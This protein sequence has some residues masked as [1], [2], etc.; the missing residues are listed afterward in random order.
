[1]RSLV[2]ALLVLACLVPT[3][4]SAADSD[5]ESRF[6]RIQRNEKQEPV[7]LQ[8][9]TVKYVPA[10]GDKGVEIDLVAVVHVGEKSYYQAFNDQFAKYDSVLYELVAP[11]GTKPSKDR[12]RRC[13]SVALATWAMSAK[14]TWALP[15]PSATALAARTSDWA[16]RTPAP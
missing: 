15:S 4:C 13:L 5:T 2:K 3:L 7:A 16:P 12:M 11:E 8:T 6:I 14:A 10:N 9:A 1:M